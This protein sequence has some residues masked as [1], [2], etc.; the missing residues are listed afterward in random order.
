MIVA[1]ARPSL[2]FETMLF[3]AIEKAFLV[4][5]VLSNLGQPWDRAYFGAAMLDGTITL[6][7][8]LC[9]ISSHGRPHAWKVDAPGFTDR[10]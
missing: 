8:L 3:A 6:Y 7:C 5:L 1:A 10:P 2:R 4:A 9:F